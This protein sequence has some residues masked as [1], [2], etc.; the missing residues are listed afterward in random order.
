MAIILDDSVIIL[1]SSRV[2]M[3]G[4]AADIRG[5][6]PTPEI[7]VIDRSAKPRV[8]GA[9]REPVIRGTRRNPKITEAG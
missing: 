3:D 8:V 4:D 5:R 1:N 7:A 6:G 9:R 2:T